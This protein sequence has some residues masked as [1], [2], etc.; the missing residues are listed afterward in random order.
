MYLPLSRFLTCCPVLAE[1]NVS[2]QIDGAITTFSGD[3]GVFIMVC[4]VR[5]SPLIVFCI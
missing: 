1:E 5:F 4:S 3:S 2:K